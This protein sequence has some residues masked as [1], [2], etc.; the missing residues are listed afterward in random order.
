[1]RLLLLPGMDG[2]GRLFA[3]LQAALPPWLPAVTV[4]YPPDQPLGYDGLLPLV[5]AAA[6]GLGEFV[7]VG[8][9][10]SGP[11]ALMLATQRPPGLRG[12]VLC[13]SF[14][15]FPLPVPQQWRGLVRPWMFRLQPTWLVA[16][17]LLGRRGVGAAGPAAA[18]GS[19]IRLASG[20]GGPSA[21][22]GRGRRDGR[23]ADLP[24]AGAVPACRR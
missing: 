21:G 17:V 5:E 1:V 6:A 9:S 24:G 20:I 18:G 4:S 15:R 2:T 23:V 16:L 12:L 10:F 3:P 22:R 19:P 14:V 13:A 8:E 7:V 11:L